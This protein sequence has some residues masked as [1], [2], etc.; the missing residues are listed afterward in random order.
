MSCNFFFE[1]WFTLRVT[2]K[3]DFRKRKWFLFCL[4]SSLG[5][6]RAE[7]GWFDPAGCCFDPRAPFSMEV[8][9]VG[10][11]GGAEV[12]SHHPVAGAKLGGAWHRQRKGQQS[13]HF[14]RVHTSRSCVCVLGFVYCWMARGP[15]LYVTKKYLSIAYGYT[16]LRK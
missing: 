7:A 1:V 10:P 5:V 6:I 15:L 3:P 11:S 9:R 12:A 2:L 16:F 4:L 8:V 14:V 13:V